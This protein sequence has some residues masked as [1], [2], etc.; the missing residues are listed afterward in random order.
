MK[1]NAIMIATLPLLLLMLGSGLGIRAAWCETPPPPSEDLPPEQSIMPPIQCGSYRDV[2]EGRIESVAFSPDGKTL[3][4]GNASGMIKY[5]DPAT[6]RPTASFRVQKRIEGGIG[7]LD[8]APDGKTLATLDALVNVA[9]LEA[10]TGRP[11]LTLESPRFSPNRSYVS[12]VAYAPDGK[13]VAAGYHSGEVVLWDAVTGRRRFVMP[14]YIIPEHT[15]SAPFPKVT[16]AHPAGIASL[17]FSPDGAT[18]A[19]LGAVVRLW[20]VATGQERRT[21]S[22]P[23]HRYSSR[24]A[25]SA[26]GGTLAVG[27]RSVEPGGLP[28]TLTFW[29]PETGRKRAESTTRE[30]ISGLAYLPGGRTLV[31]LEREDVIR[32]RDAEA[33]QPLAGLRFDHHYEAL[34]LAISPDGRLIAAGGASRNGGFWFIQL[35]ETDGK[36]LRPWKPKP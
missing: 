36:T 12:A 26:D 23:M 35:I 32:L 30:G 1:I 8:F 9:L 22:K 21:L 4:A 28:T 33:G 27:D 15:F 25:F 18:L 7:A 16:L 20:D 34:C 17:V 19:S 2:D 24:L 3:A 14:P 11:R 6:A 5:F 10:A 13:A 31:S 29:D